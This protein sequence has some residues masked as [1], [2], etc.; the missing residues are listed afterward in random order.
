MALSNYL[1]ETVVATA[2]MY[3][4]GLGWFGEVSR[5]RQL[6]LALIIYLGL[7]VLSAIWLR[8]FRMGPMEWLWRSI[9]Y[10]RPQPLVRS[11][12]DSSTPAGGM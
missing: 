11:A 4:W 8:V 2:L 10:W 1:L 7:V 5:P 12:T 6:A 9:T 3:W